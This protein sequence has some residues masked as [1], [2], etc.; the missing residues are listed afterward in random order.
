MNKWLSELE[1]QFYGAATAYD[2]ALGGPGVATPGSGPGA[3]P[4]AGPGAPPPGGAGARAALADA[5]L[6]NVYGDDDA[7]RARALDLADYCMHT[8][9][10]LAQTE[11]ASVLAGR[12]RFGRLGGGARA[13]ARA[14]GE[15]MPDAPSGTYA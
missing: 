3:A 12:V 14:A 15:A 10:C 9:A 7:C 2:R 8:L 13:R 1:R 6:R 4:A 5:L 11:G